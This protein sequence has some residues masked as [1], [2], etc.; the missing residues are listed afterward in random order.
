MFSNKSQYQIKKSKV[1]TRYL[2]YIEELYQII[3]KNIDHAKIDKKTICKDS[4]YMYYVKSFFPSKSRS[5]L[6]AILYKRYNLIQSESSIS[7][8]SL[9]VGIVIAANN[10]M[11][12]LG[13][14]NKGALLALLPS[15]VVPFNS[16]LTVL[17]WINKSFFFFLRSWIS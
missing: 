12:Y 3:D 17:I 9:N 4:S 5:K 16:G 7:A 13:I 1:I 11:A 8:Y 6:S 14:L 15:N 2:K 10:M